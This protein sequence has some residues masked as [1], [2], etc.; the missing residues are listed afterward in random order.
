MVNRKIIIAFAI[1]FSLVIGTAYAANFYPVTGSMQLVGDGTTGINI[2]MKNSNGKQQ[3]VNFKNL[4]NGLSYKF[5]LIQD[6]FELI[7]TT[8][9]RTDMHIQNI[10][11]NIAI[12]HAN[13][14]EKLDINGDLRLRGGNIINPG[15]DICI[16]DCQ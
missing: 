11:G 15:G 3:S 14:T 6:N 10:T 2:I 16:G 12:G 1:A 5:R 9:Q 4:D 13:P 7:E 8:T